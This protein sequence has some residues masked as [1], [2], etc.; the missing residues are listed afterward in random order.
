MPQTTRR[1]LLAALGIAPAAAIAPAVVAALPDEN[2]E[3]L[4]WGERLDGL[5]ETY[6][7]ADRLKAEAKAR[8]HALCPVPDELIV[9]EWGIWS[10]SC[11]REK[12]WDGRFIGEPS[13][14]VLMVRGLELDAKDYRP[15]TKHGKL[16]RMK[17][18]IAREYEAVK[19]R[20][21]KASGIREAHA[22]RRAAESALEEAVKAIM[23]LPAETM[24]GVAVKAKAMLVH[25]ETNPPTMRASWINV[26]YGNDLAAEIVKVSSRVA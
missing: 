17:L 13:R 21:E 2:P 18:N 26:L 11:E 12:D 25:A 16:V 19:E 6:R 1:S 4:A 9:P 22:A 23:P 8:Y 24:A 5:G 7:E 14:Y 3:L 15:R 10:G 20:A